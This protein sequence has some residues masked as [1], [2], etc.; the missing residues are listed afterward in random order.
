MIL[1]FIPGHFIKR[2]DDFL[3]R[4]DYFIRG[5]DYFI[6]GLDGSFGRLFFQV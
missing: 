5:L 6:K 3:K 4:L 1:I 2:L